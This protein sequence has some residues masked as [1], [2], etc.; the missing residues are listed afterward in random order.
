MLQ[1]DL[2]GTGSE[3]G[4]TWSA[5]AH[6]ACVLLAAICS[7]LSVELCMPCRAWPAPVS[8]RRFSSSSTSAASMRARIWP[9]TRALVV[10]LAAASLRASLCAS[11]SASTFFFRAISSSTARFLTEASRAMAAWLGLGLGLR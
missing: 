5:S 3:S 6:A 7:Q 11:C 10:R 9:S 8:L 2:S 4:L 1:G